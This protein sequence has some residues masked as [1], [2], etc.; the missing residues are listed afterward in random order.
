MDG[1][2]GVDAQQ[3]L[4]DMGL[5][6][7][8]QKEYS[9]VDDDGNAMVELGYVDSISPEA[10]TSVSSGDTVTLTVS[11]G[12]DYGE[13]VQVPN[14]VGLT[15]NDAVTKF[16]KFL[17]VEVKEEQST[18]V[19]AGEVISQ[20]PEADSWEDPD[21]ANVVITVSTGTQ[22]TSQDTTSQQNTDSSTD[23]VADTA[24]QSTAA[25]NGEVWKCTQA[26]EYTGRIFRRLDPS[27]TDPD[28]KRYS[29][30]IDDPGW[31]DSGI[32]V[33]PGCNGAPGV[34]EGTICL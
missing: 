8:V 30:C 22:D 9:E 17:N 33:F 16:S 13:S 7:T 21:T 26:A 12:I 4:E 2:T 32:P 3:T 25:A 34:S 23:T 29:Y 15:K 24:Q 11:R 14:V 19:A 20:E 5:N 28:S 6:V 10:G 27:G 31:T 1:R 18:D